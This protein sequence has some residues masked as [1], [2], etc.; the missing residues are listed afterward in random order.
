[1]FSLLVGFCA[2]KSSLLYWRAGE[3]DSKK[4]RMR[5]EERGRERE[6]QRE[7]E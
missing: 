1:M 7:A 5:K 4:E 2:R 3:R 6:R